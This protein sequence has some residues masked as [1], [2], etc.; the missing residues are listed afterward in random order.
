MRRAAILGFVL[1]T[2][3]AG[4]GAARAQNPPD[5][6]ASVTLVE[7]KPW[8]APDEDLELAVRVTTNLPA[9]GAELA[10][11]LCSRA[12][13]RSEF[14][15]TV[16]DKFRCASLDFLNTTLTKLAV[17][18]DGVYRM[19]MPAQNHLHEPGVYP[20][21][22][23]LRTSGRTHDQ[24]DHFVT[25]AVVVAATPPE[26]RLGVGWVVPIEATPVVAADGT[27]SVPPPVADRMAAAVQAVASHPG[28]P[29]TI[30]PTPAV[31]DVLAASN[32]A[33]DQQTVEALTTEAASTTNR[34]LLAAP[35]VPIDLRGMTGA[36]LDSEIAAQAVQGND[37]LGE[38]LKARPDPRTWVAEVPLDEQSVAALSDRGIDRLVLPESGLAAIGLNRT[39]TQPFAIEARQGRRLSAAAADAGLSAHFAPSDD[40]SLA[41]HQLLA[42]LAM[43]YFDAPGSR[44]PRA[45]VAVPPRGWTPD[46]TFL[47][48][49]LDGL[50]A[51]PVLSGI[52]LDQL[53]ST[54]TP[55]AATKGRGPLVRTLTPP[56][57]DSDAAPSGTAVRTTRRRL[58]A[59]GSMLEPDNQPSA[60]L[61][62]DFQRGL[63][64]AESADLR[65]RQHASAIDAV[66]RRLDQQL[67][68]VHMPA[69][70]SVRLTARR[71]DVP[72]TVLS[73]APYPVHVVLH[74]DR[75]DKL[76]FTVP[77]IPP[78]TRRATIVPLG[79]AVR[80]SGAFP[81]RVS[82]QSPA[83]G[84]LLSQTHYT[85]RSTAASG[86]GVVLSVGAGLF[87]LVWWGRNLRHGRRARQ[88][89][90]A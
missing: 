46:I 16:Q 40:P 74:I 61:F 87:L 78:L 77:E 15:L 31:L 75:S 7:Q 27:R 59:F 55:A 90:P 4:A 51:S 64:L 9:D 52:T 8:L 20:V 5:Q 62:D 88:L 30:D 57:P 47:T 86:V 49:A 76:R 29:L 32:R 23:E 71:G 66:D 42:D 13:T 65:G 17:D 89:V 56:P 38:K 69:N 6:T 72:V 14:A 79:V 12:A 36:G 2:L 11:T 43:I 58:N 73:D 67:A 53:F 26:T 82:V 70:R 19:R 35:Y 50:S 41:A 22:V 85:V 44:T 10:L 34:Q 81:L 84:V 60:D 1:L 45:V 28:V 18:S 54:V 24:L 25:H 83:E 39:L 68:L 33:T 63:L 48:T 37:T 21:R 80:T 3:I